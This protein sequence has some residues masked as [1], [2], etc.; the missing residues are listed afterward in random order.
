VIEPASGMVF[1]GVFHGGVYASADGGRT[2]QRRDRGMTEDDVF[3]LA[4]RR[5]GDRVRLYAGTEPAH[6]FYSDDLGE[7]WQ[8]IPSLRSVA[9]VPEWTYPGP[10]HVAHVKHINFAPDDPRTLYVSIEQGALLKSTDDAATWQDLEVPYAD[11]HRTVIDPRDPRRVMVTGGRGIWCSADSGANWEH[12]T[13]PEHPIGG[14]PDQL[15]FRPSNPDRLFVGAGQKPPGLWGKDGTSNTRISRSQDGGQTWEQLR[16]GLP[17]YME[18]S[19]E[20]MLLEEAGDQC[21]LMCATT[22]GDVLRSEDAGGHWAVV[23]RD[24]AVAK[25]HHRRFTRLAQGRS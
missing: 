5:I 9:S 18:R 3:S 22:G 13:L 7:N 25:G 16:G 24:V 19:V 4:Y 11:I 6:L 14:Y 2:F 8:E 17:D 12:R 15:V 20:A 1:A 10:P 21:A 23:L